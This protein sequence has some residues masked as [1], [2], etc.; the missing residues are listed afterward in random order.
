MLLNQMAWLVVDN[1]KVKER[2]LGFAKDVASMAVAASKGED[3][4]IMDTMARV[5][6]DSGDKAKAIEWQKKAI[7]KAQGDMLDELKSTLKK[8]E[9]GDAPTPT[10]KSS[11]RLGD[12]APA[13]PKGDA[14]KA[15]AAPVAPAAPAGEPGMPRSPRMPRPA[16]KLSP[17]AEKVFPAVPSEGFDSTDDIVK[18]L[19]SAAK[20]ANG[21]LRIVKA[22]RS[23]SDSGKISLRVAAALI[24]DMSPVVSASV[25]KFGKAGSMPIPVPANGAKYEVKTDGDAA[26][27][28]VALDADGKVLGQPTALVKADGKWWF[29]FDKAAGMRG[30]DGSQ[31]AMMANMMGEAMRSSIK[32]A[33]ASTAKD[34]KEGKFKSIEEANQAFGQAMQMEMMKVM[35]GPGGGPGAGG[36]G[37]G[38]PGAGGPGGVK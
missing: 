37:A 31:M 14:P 16:P 15:P 4:A 33:A 5:C 34:V 11:F 21:T 24:E 19:P 20:D 6:W 30:D 10:K 35:G 27:T 17:A 7:A 25:E 36:P 26:A 3:G 9:S 38:G 22:M 23:T 8:Y 18:F 12:D 1:L 29:D 13:A 2:D 32:S 28:I